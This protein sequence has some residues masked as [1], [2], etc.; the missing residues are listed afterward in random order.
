M[1]TQQI[2]ISE[3]LP[4]LKQIDEANT[5][6]CL[7]NSNQ[8]QDDKSKYAFI[9]G[10]GV[11]DQMLI[12][13]SE[14]A[15]NQ[16]AE[17][18]KKHLGTFLFAALSYDLKNEIENLKSNNP[19]NFNLP[20]LYFY[21]PKSFLVVGSLAEFEGEHGINE[22]KYSSFELFRKNINNPEIITFDEL[23]ER[24]KFIVESSSESA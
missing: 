15:F 18:Q 17:F 3:N 9:L 8:Y 7:L 14:N 13:T 10:I 22:D 24:A 16:L 11:V 4:S 20:N 12:N 23:Y 5:V 19:D 21:Q 2:Y 6:F 1:S